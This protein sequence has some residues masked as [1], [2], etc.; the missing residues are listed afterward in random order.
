MKKQVVLVF[1]LALMLEATSYGKTE[2]PSSPD[3]PDVHGMLVFGE[4][5]TYLSHLPMFRAP[6]NYQLIMAAE[7]GTE[8][9]SVYLQS[10]RKY[11]TER[12][13][14]LA[15]VPFVLPEIVK[16]GKR[17]TATLYRGHFERGGVPIANDITVEIKKVVFFEKLVSDETKPRTLRYILF[18]NGK[19]WYL[20][21]QIVAAPDFD[22]IITLRERPQIW[23]KQLKKNGKIF[24]T[25]LDSQDI[26]PLEDGDERSVHVSE[27][28]G[29]Q[30]ILKGI[31][32]DYLEFDDLA[33]K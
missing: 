21:H 25:I 30:T 10:R 20:A 12:I 27:R 23:E 13:Y 33:E 7:F 11:P 22:Q 26:R 5:E 9:K 4:E 2:A 6:H 18:G 24:L 1:A 17:F 19:E 29:T 14:T 28:Q 32:V 8:V 16:N 15:P 31:K 3:S